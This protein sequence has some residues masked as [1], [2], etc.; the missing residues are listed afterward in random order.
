M[1]R[2]ASLLLA[3]LLVPAGAGCATAQTRGPGEA[4][5]AT[6][7]SG[8]PAQARR[9]R[10]Y[11]GLEI[12]GSASVGPDGV[13]TASYP[14]VRA[15]HPDSPGHE[16]GVGTGDVIIEVNGRDSRE[17]GAL[18]WQ[19]GVRYTLRIRTGDAE[20]EVAMVPLP[21]RT[22]PSTPSS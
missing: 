4:A 20:R 3:V 11:T 8:Q 16:A 18:W 1:R 10:A 7:P 6:P 9:A 21:P 19:P 12:S 15:V 22:P 14:V 17:Q 2:A 5:S 13:V